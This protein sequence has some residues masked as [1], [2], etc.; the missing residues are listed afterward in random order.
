LMED[1]VRLVF[2]LQ[3]DGVASRA[4]RRPP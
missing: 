3:T 1:V 4:Y 2:D